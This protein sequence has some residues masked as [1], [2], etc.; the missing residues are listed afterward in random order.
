MVQPFQIHLC[1]LCPFPRNSIELKFIN[2]LDNAVFFLILAKLNNS[3][4]TPLSV[5]WASV[6]VADSTTTSRI[7]FYTVLMSWFGQH[8]H[9][10]VLEYL[11]IVHISFLFLL[12]IREGRLQGVGS[13]LI[14]EYRMVCHVLMGEFSKDFF[15]VKYAIF[16][17]SILPNYLTDTWLTLQGCR[18]LLIDKDRNPKVRYVHLIMD[19]SEVDILRASFMLLLSFSHVFSG[20]R[21]D[22]T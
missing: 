19:N 7:S 8:F 11:Q 13:C 22:W 4:E 3:L 21:L 20:S 12:Q 9:W 5:P 15:E 17:L 16:Q 18:A 14:R 10:R 2:Y 6:L 1:W